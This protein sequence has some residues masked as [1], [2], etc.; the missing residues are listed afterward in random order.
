LVGRKDDIIKTRGEKVSPQEVEE[1]LYCIPGVA[2]AVVVAV[3][4]AV[5]GNAIKAIV[6]PQAGCRLT[7]KEVL[8]Y[9]SQ[10]LEDVA[11]PRSID[12]RENLPRTSSGKIA[13]RE[14][15]T[16]EVGG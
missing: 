15:T 4:D 13:R 7:E 3:P 6:V 10:H 14:L 9:C 1:V 12:I 16:A 5:L 11:V 8:R 2:E